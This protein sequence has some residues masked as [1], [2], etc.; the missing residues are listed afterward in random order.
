MPTIYPHLYCCPTA[1]ET[2]PSGASH[3]RGRGLRGPM[4]GAGFEAALFERLPSH[5]R[6]RAPLPGMPMTTKS[7]KLSFLRRFTNASYSRYSVTVSALAD[8]IEVEGSRVAVGRRAHADQ[9]ELVRRHVRELSVRLAL[10]R[11]LEPIVGPSCASGS[12]RA[13]RRTSEPQQRPYTLLRKRARGLVG[14]GP[15]LDE[16]RGEVSARIMMMS[17]QTRTAP[18]PRHP[19]GGG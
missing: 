17:E 8:R 15:A 5:H 9:V 19:D 3:L 11:E 7:T 14:L 16:C 1:L 6:H 10:G 4:A 18:G 2:V 13:P 12:R